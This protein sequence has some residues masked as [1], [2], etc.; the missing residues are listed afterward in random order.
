MTVFVKKG[1]QKMGKKYFLGVDIGT[2]ESKGLL[3]DE[4]CE[5]VATHAERHEMENPAPNH[6]EM[7]AEAVW[8]GDFCKI[9]RALLEKTGISNG[10]IQC[11]GVSTMGAGLVPV[12]EDCMPL[13]KAIPYGIDA[14]AEKEIEAMYEKY[15][16]EEVLRFNGRPL[17]ANDVPPKI[18]WIR[19]HYPEIYEK[20]H[21]FLTGSSF[22]TAKL[23]GKYVIDRFLG[24]GGF[25]PLYDPDAGT[26]NEKYCRD[27]CRP[28][29]LAE[30][31]DNTDIVGTVTAKAAAQT[32][33]LE[34][35]PVI[36]GADDS[37]AE[38][39]S[40]GILEVGDLMIQ[41]GSTLYFIGIADHLAHDRRIWSGGFLIPKTNSVQGGT[42]A[43][44]TLTRWYRDNLF[45][46][47]L[48]LE[49]EGGPDAY[50]TMMEGLAEIPAGSDGLITLPYIAGERTP[51][52]DPKA[53]GVIFGLSV[54]HTRTHLYHS[55]LES[56]GY[57]IAN[58]LAIFR[59]NDAPPKRIFAVGGGTK[60]PIW[61]QMIADITG[62]N[63]HTA[64]VTIG[65]AYG[66][67]LLAA[68]ATGHI[69]KFADIRKYITEGVC[70]K[71]NP[72]NHE[73]YKKYHRIFNQLY[74]NT[75]ELMHQL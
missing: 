43:A 30:L 33:L 24:Y 68:I 1:A 63:I 38:A 45:F 9:S 67:A 61:M 20:A 56:I 59:E 64:N 39:I 42:N 28:E 65:A 47:A 10:D 18:L 66:D 52:N 57:S 7:D 14:R 50:E 70:Y 73:A 46:D 51:I 5:V 29:Q 44:G 34:G 23:T 74:E 53:K 15:G 3:M 26:V 69:E 2:F 72:E 25:T 17:C 71:P 54:Q 31:H 62:E 21:K 36:T 55:A 12:D 75:K 37:G 16:E 22:M 13:L 49:K 32:G 35:T 11:V 6:F 40:T 27:F 58:H 41:L 8:W 48:A 4:N 19:N 60:N